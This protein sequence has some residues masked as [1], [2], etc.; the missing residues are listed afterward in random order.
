MAERVRRRRW[1]AGLVSITTRDAEILATIGDHRVVRQT[2]LRG[3]L[4]RG[5][6]DPTP[7]SE[8][9]V[10]LWLD[11]MTRAGLVHRTRAAGM[12]WVQLT[13]A[14]GQQVDVPAD[15][16]RFSTWT[17]DHATAVLRLRIL[18][19]GDHPSAEWRSER[20]WR[21]RLQAMREVNKKAVLSLPDGSLHWPDDHVVAVEVELTRKH[22]EDYRSK[23][24]RYA[25]EITEVWWYC[26]AGLVEW[27]TEAIASALKPQKGIGGAEVNKALE[28][29]HRVREL[30]AGVRP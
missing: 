18:L 14:G 20:Y 24:R 12:T 30:P 25:D 5:T 26:P 21:L 27:L 15:P 29:P 28:R 3:L 22:R 10:R 13:A 4:A 23:V 9:A 16:R 2:D 19:A 7:R 17:A 6:D 11:R 1:D 8:S